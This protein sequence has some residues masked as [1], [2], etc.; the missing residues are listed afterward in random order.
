MSHRG[1]IGR[2][3]HFNRYYYYHHYY[4]SGVNSKGVV[5][6]N[7]NSSGS[8][9][10]GGSSCACACACAGGGRAGCSRKDF[11]HH[12]IDITKVKDRLNKKD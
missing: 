4:S 8:G 3:T 5:I 12:S 2:R 7:P 6:V 11:N 9:V 1:F 10:S